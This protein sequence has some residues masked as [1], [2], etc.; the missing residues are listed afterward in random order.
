MVLFCLP[1]LCFW[2]LCFF[3]PIHRHSEWL[4]V[5]MRDVYR[6]ATHS[7]KDLS[8]FPYTYEGYERFRETDRQREA[9]YLTGAIFLADNESQVYPKQIIDFY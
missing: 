1:L 6:H 3:L 5:D 9:S 7:G 2:L 8:F 4:F